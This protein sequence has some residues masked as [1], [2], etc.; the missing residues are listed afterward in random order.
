MT[1]DVCSQ[2]FGPSNQRMSISLDG[3]FKRYLRG[4]NF[5]SYLLQATMCVLIMN[6]VGVV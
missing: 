3:E 4:V 5:T 6:S 2:S 1:N